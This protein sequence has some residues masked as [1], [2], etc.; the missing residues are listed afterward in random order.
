MGY[1]KP[2]VLVETDWVDARLN[3]PKVKL[4]EVDVDIDAYAE[5]G[6][7]PGAVAWNWTTQLQDPIR[8]DIPTKEQIENC[9][10]TGYP[11]RRHHHPVR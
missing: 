6:H 4:V 8:R 1:A 9:S 7:I 5:E 11:Q 10:R 2:N 3:D